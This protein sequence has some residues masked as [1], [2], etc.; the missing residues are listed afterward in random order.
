MPSSYRLELD[1][2][3]SEL[4]VKADK[5]LDIGGA[6]DSVIRKVKSWSVNTYHIADLEEPHKLNNKVD[7]KLNL[8]KRYLGKQDIY[9]VVFCLEVMEYVYD[10]MT[11]LKNIEML[12]TTGGCAYI[13]FP[14]FY[15]LHEPV[16][17]DALRYMPSGIVKL[18]EAANLSVES[19]IKRHP[20]TNYLLQ[21]FSA[22]RMRAAKG[23]DHLFTGFI[24]CLQK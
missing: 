20:E 12:L 15:P 18:A 7:L 1:K 8:N 16:E 17:D 4:E 13:T 6:Q 24:V 23:Q 22:E 11:A 21:F 19:M 9:D 3:L 2:W 10:P 14:S 5:V